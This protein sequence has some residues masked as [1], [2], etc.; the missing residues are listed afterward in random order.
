ML[1][2]L[3]TDTVSCLLTISLLVLGTKL[4]LIGFCNTWN[5]KCRILYQGCNFRRSPRPLSTLGMGT[6]TLLPTLTGSK[7]LLLLETIRSACFTRALPLPCRARLMLDALSHN[8]HVDISSITVQLQ[9]V[10]SGADPKGASLSGAD[11]TGAS[12]SG[13]HDIFVGREYVY[14]FVTK[15]SGNT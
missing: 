12:L 15:K 13:I 10:H 4:S 14:N 6:N 7:I 8:L 3:L 2:L 5:L 1:G 11:P 9:F